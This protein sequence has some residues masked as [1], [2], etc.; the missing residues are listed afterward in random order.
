MIRRTTPSSPIFALRDKLRRSKATATGT[1][2]SSR[3]R[4]GSLQDLEV[5]GGL[6]VSTGEILTPAA[7]GAVLTPPTNTASSAGTPAKVAGGGFD[8]A[9][10]REDDGA[11]FGG[12][13]SSSGQQQIQVDGG[14]GGGGG[15]GTPVGEGKGKR[16]A[17]AR[18]LSRA[19]RRF[20]NKS[21]S[22]PETLTVGRA[23]LGEA[24]SSYAYDDDRDSYGGGNAGGAGGTVA[25]GA[26][27]GQLASTR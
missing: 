18:N 5:F 22:G 24:S 7:A 6:S 10:R 21:A 16:A 2:S 11:G 1:G 4:S 27:P 8:A 25:V 3:R 15:G 23:S 19:A 9:I 26:S 14:S 12:G 13:A 17:L 20:K